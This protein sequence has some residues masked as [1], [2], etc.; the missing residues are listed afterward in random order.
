[1]IIVLFT[2]LHPYVLAGSST[3]FWLI[4]PPSKNCY[5]NNLAASPSREIRTFH[6]KSRDELET[7]GLPP[8]AILCSSLKP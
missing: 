6:G 3:S 2:L 5:S 4:L 7:N 8:I 1:M